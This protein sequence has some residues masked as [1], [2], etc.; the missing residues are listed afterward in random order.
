M[1]RLN[2]VVKIL[3]LESLHELL[4]QTD[5]R[6]SRLVEAVAVFD[7]IQK[8][9]SSS[10][11]SELGRTL[12]LERSEAIGTEGIATIGSLG[13]GILAG[14]KV[15]SHQTFVMGAADRVVSA[16]IRIPFGGG[17]ECSVLVERRGG[18]LDG[19]GVV[20]TLGELEGEKMARTI[21]RIDELRACVGIERSR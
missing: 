6:S 3:Q 18:V 12:K 17:R 10:L 1:Q 14:D 8:R 9:G 21:R 13:I 20:V 11:E 4:V 5:A 2:R 7:A 19:G 16:D 15:Q